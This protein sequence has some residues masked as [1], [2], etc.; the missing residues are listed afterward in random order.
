MFNSSETF[1]IQHLY[2]FSI[3][4]NTRIIQNRNINEENI[5]QIEGKY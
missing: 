5:K 3:Q 2:K 4:S 1:K